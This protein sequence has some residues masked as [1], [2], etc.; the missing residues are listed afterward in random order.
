MDP[1]TAVAASGM[2]A[3]ME[4]LE[5]LANNLA[6]ASTGGYKAD[7]EFYSLYRAA[8]AS[9]STA[10]MPLI[11]RQWTDHSQGT[12]HATGN[13]L[14]VALSGPGYFAV[15]GP[16]GPL[17]TRNGNFQVSPQGRLV[18][19]EG[20]P[21]RGTAGAVLTLDPARPV[22][23]DRGGTIRQAGR[24]IGQLDIG[25]F[26]STASLTKQGKTYFRADPAVRPVVAPQTVVGQGQLEA[27]NV[28]TAE[29]AVRLVNV[30]RQFEMLQRAVALG[31]DMNRKAIE[32]VA[33]VGA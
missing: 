4:S 9:D 22:E 25:D 1:L 14:D 28:G 15:D 2:R 33:R 11:E 17:Y 20:Y 31:G 26:T 10:T 29:S 3:R 18:T 32:E 8:E 30:M 24:V 7:R 12:V 19:S 16:A 23:I 21:V 13:P 5:L 6:N 27:S